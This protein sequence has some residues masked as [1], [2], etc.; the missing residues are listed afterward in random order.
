MAR[1]REEEGTDFE[2]E[3]SAM[4]EREVH[5]GTCSNQEIEPTP[6]GSGSFT[7][8]SSNVYCPQ[9]FKF[10]VGFHTGIHHCITH[11]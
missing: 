7:V 3:S 4:L 1:I 9:M 8:H 11:S 10:K 5:S 2:S 6:D